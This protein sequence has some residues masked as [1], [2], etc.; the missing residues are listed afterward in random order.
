MP[1]GSKRPDGGSPKG[2][3]RNWGTSVTGPHHPSAARRLAGRPGPWGRASATSTRWGALIAQVA[4]VSLTTTVPLVLGRRGCSWLW[5]QRVVLPVVM[6]LDVT[7]PLF[8]RVASV[9]WVTAVRMHSVLPRSA[10]GMLWISTGLPMSFPAS[11]RVVPWLY[12][13]RLR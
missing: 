8:A 2:R 12:H 6:A 4:G 13:L 1:R 9:L 7:H 10:A 11:K 3:P 5:D